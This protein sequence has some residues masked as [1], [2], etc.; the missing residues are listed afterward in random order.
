MLELVSVLLPYAWNTVT[1]QKWLV[2]REHQW[3]YPPPPGDLSLGS[4]SCLLQE[5]ETL[6]D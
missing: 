2:I 4:I 1:W 6:V 5:R 3:C